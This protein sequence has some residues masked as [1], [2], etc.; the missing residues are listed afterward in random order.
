MAR[1]VADR[2]SPM[3]GGRREFLGV[4]KLSTTDQLTTRST[5]LQRRQ[6][7]ASPGQ[8]GR[9]PQSDTGGA[10][11]SPVLEL[12]EACEPLRVPVKYSARTQ[13][14]CSRDAT[15]TASPSARQLLVVEAMRRPP[16]WSQEPLDDSPRAGSCEL[17]SPHSEATGTTVA[18]SDPS[19]GRLQEWTTTRCPLIPRKICLPL[20]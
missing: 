14:G 15:A 9:Q 11:A 18:C 8:A 16:G 13:K 12:A 5:L 1:E 7:R 10:A 20:R 17:A 2:G 19:S 3:P 4:G 6:R